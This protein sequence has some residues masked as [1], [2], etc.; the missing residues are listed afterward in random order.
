MKTITYIQPSHEKFLA[1][2]QYKTGEEKSFD[3]V[4]GAY[5]K[6]KYLTTLIDINGD[7]VVDILDDIYAKITFVKHKK[8]VE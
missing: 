3:Y 7:D 8:D 5:K 4:V 6:E 2:V 1:K